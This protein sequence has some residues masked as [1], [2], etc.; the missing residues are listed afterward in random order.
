MPEPQR[1]VV[2]R[3]ALAL[4]GSHHPGGSA[5]PVDKFGGRVHP[6]YTCSSSVSS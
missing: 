2:A 4:V 6:V 5:A 1:D 3:L